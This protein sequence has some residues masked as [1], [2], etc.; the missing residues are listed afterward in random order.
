MII[1]SDERCYILNKL[2]VSYKRDVQFPD[3][4]CVSADGVDLFLGSEEEVTIFLKGIVVGSSL[5]IVKH[6]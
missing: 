1:L 4:F 5:Q 3:K 2:G 6:N